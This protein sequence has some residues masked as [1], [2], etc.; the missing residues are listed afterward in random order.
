MKGIFLTALLSFFIHGFSH[1]QLRVAINGGAHQSKI[2]E[3]NNIPGWDTLKNS[4]SGRDGVHLGFMAD[5]RF[6]EKSNFYFQPGVSFFTKGRNYKSPS[7][8]STVVFKQPFGMPDSIVNTY[9]FQTRK[10][11]INYIDLPLNVVF[12]LK[13]GKNVSFLVGGGPYLSFFYGGSHTQEDVLADVRVTTLETK[14]LPV[15]DGA[16]KYSTLDYGVNGLAGFEFGRVF[17]TANYSRGLRDFYK[18]ADYLASDYKH[19]IFGATL[20]IFLGKVKPADADKDGT[21][22]KTDQC[23]DIPGP[24]ELLGCPDTDKDGITDNIDKCPAEAGFADNQGCPYVDKDGDG[25]V[26]K[27]D[28]CPEQSGPRDNRGCPYPDTDKDGIADKDDKCPSVAGYARYEGCPIPDQDEDGINDEEDKCP[29]EKGIASNYGCPEAIKKEIIQKVDYAAKRIQFRSS[30]AELSA[31]SFKVL[32]EVVALLKGNPGIK[33]RIEGHSSSD[34]NY[35]ENVKLS[36][37]RAESVKK[38]LNSR[39]IENE[40]LSSIGYGPDRPLNSGKS[41]EEKIRNR[42]VELKL[43]NQ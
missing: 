7:Q 39:G 21:P 40:R 19:E 22:D 41:K 34:G 5:L 25:T 20:G 27:D 14:D 11:F 38:Y 28:N 6:S 30:S 1:A 23:P 24:V 35:Q 33:V 32:D 31:A 12:K 9:Y 26:D 18:P 8:D 17:L 13:L 36:K 10:Q 3:E 2:L 16:G 4:Y 43:S 29:T 15:G 37:S 42:R